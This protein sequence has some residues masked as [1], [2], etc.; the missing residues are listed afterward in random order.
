MHNLKW[1][2]DAAALKAVYLLSVPMV[3]FYVAKENTFTLEAISKSFIDTRTA[4]VRAI[5][6]IF[7]FW[8]KVDCSRAQ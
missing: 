7:V 8:D 6:L 1:P 5:Y 2:E 3:E 4:A